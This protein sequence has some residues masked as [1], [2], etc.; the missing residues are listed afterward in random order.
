M[1]NPHLVINVVI[2]SVF[3]DVLSL[4]NVAECV[5][6]N[7]F[8]SYWYFSVQ[9]TYQ[10]DLF[11]KRKNNFPP[12]DALFG[13][14]SNTTVGASTCICMHTLTYKG[15]CMY[16]QICTHTCTCMDNK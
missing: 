6:I 12:E 9:E 1:D 15:I 11:F 8:I 7:C 14:T 5:N 2:F 16:L 3:D 13:Q 10:T 4:L